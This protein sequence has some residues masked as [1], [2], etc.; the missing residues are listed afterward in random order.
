MTLGERLRKLRKER[1]LTLAD[2]SSHFH[3]RK[4]TFSNYE[5][6]YRKP[7]ADL[8]EELADYF[9]VSVD[10]LLGRTNERNPM[11]KLT[12]LA[13]EGTLKLLTAE[14]LEFLRELAQDEQRQVLLRESRGLTDR[15]LAK[16]IRIIKAFV[17]EEESK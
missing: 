2:L 10:Y 17:E 12:A 15:D 1:N 5:N 8:L 9:N 16:A 6:D 11:E 13:P 7:N 3:M 14:E 4:S